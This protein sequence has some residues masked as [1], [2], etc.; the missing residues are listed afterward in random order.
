MGFKTVFL[1]LRCQLVLL[2]PII[3][4]NSNDTLY[5][6]ITICRVPILGV[7]FIHV[8]SFQPQQPYQ[9]ITIIIPI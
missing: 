4:N 7:Y 3:N 8:I 6:V 1:S 9:V 5:R 2:L